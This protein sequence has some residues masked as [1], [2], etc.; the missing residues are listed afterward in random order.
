M[1]V[2]EISANDTDSLG[3]R[4]KSCTRF[5]LL[6]LVPI[7]GTMSTSTFIPVESIKGVQFSGKHQDWDTWRDH[8]YARAAVYRYDDVIRGLKKIPSI[9]EI[10]AINESTA[11]DEEKKK[12]QVY[13]LNSS[14]YGQL[15]TS[16]NMT[17]ADGKVAFNLVRQAVTADLPHGDVQLAMKRLDDYY[18]PK[19]VATAQVLQRQ[20]DSL[21]LKSQQDPGKFMTELQNLRM[22]IAAID[23]KKVFDDD[24]LIG[25][26]L[27][28]LTD[29]YDVTV[30]MIE[31]KMD[32]NPGSVTIGYLQSQ[33]NLRFQR[34]YGFKGLPT[35]T[36]KSDKTSTADEQALYSGGF[37]SK[38]RTCGKM[39]HKFYQCPM[40]STVPTGDVSVVSSVTGVSAVG[41]QSPNFCRYCKETGHVLSDCPKLKAKEARKANASRV[42][43]IFA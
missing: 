40:K 1:F 19:T 14:A 34:L 37:K 8:F 3:V 27:N 36:E 20:F 28:S 31:Y 43:A 22:R 5:L 25:H 24:R 38:C 39:G 26:V 10:R 21:K 33:L 18:H 12:L 17:S 11:S 4:L 9:A 16:I 29:D 42:S 30:N 7:L 2:D 13:Q 15:L 35:I 23:P 6:V 32:E 41:S